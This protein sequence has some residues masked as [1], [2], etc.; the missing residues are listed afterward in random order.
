MFH[1][2][3]GI[4]QVLAGQLQA[5]LDVN[6]LVP[7][8]SGLGYGTDTALVSWWMTYAKRWTKGV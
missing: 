8:Q 7:F 5:F 2:W 1:F 6:C 3:Q 4:E